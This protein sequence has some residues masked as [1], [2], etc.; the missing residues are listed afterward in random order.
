MSDDNYCFAQP[1]VVEQPSNTDYWDI[2]VVDD[3]QDIHDVTKMVFNDSEFLDH[4]FRFSHAYSAKEAKEQLLDNENFAVLLLD[5]VMETRQA[6]LDLAKWV[7]EDLGNRHSRIILRTGQPGDAPEESVIHNYDINDYKNKTELSSTRLTTTVFSAVRSYN[8][9]LTIEHSEKALKV[10][11][12]LTSNVFEENTAETWLEGI[13]LQLASVLR[14]E[15]AHGFGF[16]AS[17]VGGEWTVVSSTDKKS[18]DIGDPLTRYLDNRDVD[19]F[20]FNGQIVEVSPSQFVIPLGV[21][22]SLGIISINLPR[23][24]IE[25]H[26][27]LIEILIRSASI[28]YDKFFL[29][30]EMIAT[31]R[32]AAYRFGEVITDRCKEPK[33]HIQRLSL[34]SYILALQSG[35]TEEH[36]HRIKTAIPLYHAGTIAIPDEVLF[37]S[38]TLTDEEWEVMKSHTSIGEE[39]LSGSHLEVLQ[40]ASVIASTHHEKWDGSG[41]PSGLKGS[42]IPIEGRI[43]AI[44][45]AFESMMMERSAAHPKSK[46]DITHYFHQEKSKHFDPT[47]CDVFIGIYDECVSI[48]NKYPR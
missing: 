28:A 40:T 32:E 30:E 17:P 22:N 33:N 43:I 26:R 44:A 14:L 19:S 34:V 3:E 9:I 2:L 41:Y 13:L 35:L 10:I 45:A 23:H 18:V 21:R 8:D 42:D 4:K 29:L 1:E 36:A 46:D 24:N 11:S 20:Q 15:S 47:L 27:E 31:Q 5:V 48:M 25:I 12:N 38:D 37:K 39:I 6:G 7:R 16:C